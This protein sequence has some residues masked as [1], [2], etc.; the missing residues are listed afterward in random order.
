MD[1]PTETPRFRVP[2]RAP[3]R[4]AI[5]VRTDDVTYATL[6]NMAAD[7]GRSLSNLVEQMIKGQLQAQGRIA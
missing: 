6:A 7:E 1:T 3:A 5:M 4:S 2:K